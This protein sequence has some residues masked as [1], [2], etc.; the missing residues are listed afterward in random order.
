MGYRE[1][2]ESIVGRNT[3]DEEA[4]PATVYGIMQEEDARH[5]Q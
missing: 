2:G 5:G 1:H 4:T 3:E